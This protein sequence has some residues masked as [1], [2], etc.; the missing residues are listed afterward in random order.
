MLQVYWVIRLVATVY[1]KFPWFAFCACYFGAVVCSGPQSGP[2]SALTTAVYQALRLGAC[3]L[4]ASRSGLF[5][6]KEFS[7]VSQK[8]HGL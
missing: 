1:P 3:S 5:A 7:A 4:S 8:Q 6:S 2:L